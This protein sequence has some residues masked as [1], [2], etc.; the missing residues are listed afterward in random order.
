MNPCLIHALNAGSKARLVAHEID[1]PYGRLY[2]DRMIEGT[3][4]ISVEEHKG[5]G[6]AWR[7]S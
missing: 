3:T 6:Q 2:L 7:Y 4:P 1:H 5:T